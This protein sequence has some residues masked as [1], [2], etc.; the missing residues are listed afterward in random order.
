MRTITRANNLELRSGASDLELDAAQALRYRVF[1]EELGAQPDETT[2]LAARDI[3]EFDVIADH[4]VV[5]DLDRGEQ[6]QP[7]VV[8]CYRLLRQSIADAHGGLY[9]AREF[10]LA[11]VQ[12]AA[13]ELMELGRSCVDAEYRGGTVMQLLW[14]GIADYLDEYRIG[15]MLGC[16]SLSGTDVDAAANELSYLFH[17][18][19]APANIRPRALSER[20]VGIERLPIES[21]DRK[22]ALKS[23]PPLLKAY[24]RMGGMIGDGAVIDHQFNTTDVCLVLPTETVVERYQ[25]HCRQH[26]GDVADA[27]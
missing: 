20:Y 15:L 19:L 18:H 14:R 1:Y 25:R 16:A 26:R 9:T 24:I 10:D 2:R 4:L 12:P 6:K 23:L 27:A 11:N 5:V 17:F 8:G 3:D 13:G 21:V 7:Y 22:K